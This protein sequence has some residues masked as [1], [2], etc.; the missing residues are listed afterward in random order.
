MLNQESDMFEHL[1]NGKRRLE[2]FWKEKVVLRPQP[3]SKALPSANQWPGINP[4]QILNSIQ[5]DGIFLLEDFIDKNQVATIASTMK[6]AFEEGIPGVRVRSNEK[7]MIQYVENPLRLCPEVVN[8]A[9]HPL[10]VQVIEAYFQNDCYL[11]DVDMRRVLPVSME[12]FEARSPDHKQGYSSSHWHYDVRGRQIKIM[13][14]LNDVV[15]GDQN[16]AYCPGTHLPIDGVKRSRFDRAASRF[17]DGWPESKQLK[18]VDCYVKAGT[19]A[20]FD[21]NCIHRLRRRDSRLRDSLTFYYTPGQEL[22]SL[23]VNPEDLR[24]EAKEYKRL[25]GGKRV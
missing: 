15:P 16:F 8:L 7:N 13:I 10:F 21:T 1:R 2:V 12:E 11:S 14:F 20:I 6:K 3:G 9:L 18:V 4:Q 25:L 5:K 23:D 17:P 19:A 24:G 22:F